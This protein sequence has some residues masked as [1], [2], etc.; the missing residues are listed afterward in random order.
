MKRCAI[1]LLLA[2]L[3]AL[4]S[5]GLALAG[6]ETSAS[7]QA[8]VTVSAAEFL[9][10]LAAPTAGG[11]CASNPGMTSEIGLPAPLAA[12]CTNPCTTASQCPRCPRICPAQCLSNCCLCPCR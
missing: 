7:K 9:A 1:V 8:P 5:S 3:A 12:A 10:S 4:G 2:M 11:S 6:Q